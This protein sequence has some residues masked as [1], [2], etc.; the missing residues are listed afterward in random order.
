MSEVEYLIDE[1]SRA[2]E[3]VVAAVT[4]LSAEQ[5][6]FR[7]HPDDWCIVEIMEHL[8]LTEQDVIMSTWKAL[9]DVRRRRPALAGSPIRRRP[10]V[11]EAVDGTW[12]ERGRA[13]R[14]TMP[15]SSWPLEF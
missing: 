4:G 13:S 15:I 9:G 1:V 5:A 6:E 12:R 3:R 14:Y 2:C 7:P 10:L 11:D 8:V